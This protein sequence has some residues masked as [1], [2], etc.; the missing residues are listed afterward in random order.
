MHL[1]AIA[2]GCSLMGDRWPP[3][4]YYHLSEPKLWDY[5]LHKRQRRVKHKKIQK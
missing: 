4:G 2:A 1:L 3:S 5:M